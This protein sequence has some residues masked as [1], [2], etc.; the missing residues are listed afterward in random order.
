MLCYL[1]ITGQC[2]KRIVR[3][4]FYFVQV[5]SGK[6]TEVLTLDRLFAKREGH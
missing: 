3:Q 6:D 4:L 5:H 2:L 1:G